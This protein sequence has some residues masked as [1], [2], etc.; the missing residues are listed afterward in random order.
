MPRKD[1]IA[2]GHVFPSRPESPQ[3]APTLPHAECTELSQFPTV[4]R[5]SRRLPG[6][7]VPS[8]SISIPNLNIYA[9]AL[10]THSL[11]YSPTHHLCFPTSPYTTNASTTLND[12]TRIPPAQQTPISTRPN[13]HPSCLHHLAAATH[14]PAIVQDKFQTTAQPTHPPIGTTP[15]NTPIRHD[16]ADQLCDHT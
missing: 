15:S 10:L 12:N 1:H 13:P 2:L 14:P 3:I 5:Y 6:P 4:R 9:P 8:H 11:Y 7:P 16:R